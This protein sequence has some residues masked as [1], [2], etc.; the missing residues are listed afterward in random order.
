MVDECGVCGGD[1]PGDNFDCDGNCLVDVDCN[2]DC[3]GD[4]VVDECGVCGGEGFLSCWDGSEVCDLADCPDQP[5]FFV[6]FESDVDVAGFQFN[7]DNVTILGAGGGAAADAG[8]TLSNSSSTVIGFSLT[9]GTI[10]AGEGVLV[11]VDVDG[12]IADACLSGLVFSDS[13]GTALPAEVVDC[14]TVVID[15]IETC[16]DP[17]A[18]N[19]GDDGACD[20]PEDN[21]DC[22]GNCTAE[23]DCAGDCGGDAV[24]DE[25]GVCGGPGY[26]ICW[27]GSEVCDL[28]DCPELPGGDVAILYNTDSDIAGLQFGVEGV[29]V[30]AAYG[31]A[32]E[33]AGFTV[34]TS[35]TVV[36]GFSLTGSVIEA[37]SGVLTNLTVVGETE[38]T[39]LADLIVSDPAGGAYGATVLDCTT[40]VIDEIESCEDP[41]ACN[42]GADGACEYPEDNFDCDGNCLVDVDCNGDCG[43][44][45]V[46]DECGVCGGDGIADGACDCDGNVEDCAGVC[47]GDAVVDE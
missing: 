12:N 29:E 26:S 40:I 19:T 17:D 32:A 9:G 5:A 4:A 23:E 37:G 33:A 24:V 1:G 28:A 10:P 2:G 8:F 22:D 21:F 42:T 34:S 20:Y 36:I 14:D 35:A 3:G 38:D 16:E 39:C 30:E 11:E 7:V 43:G 41:N 46:V 25:C 15:A 31:G 27:D 13:S 47:G 18:C 45:A 6:N 44:D